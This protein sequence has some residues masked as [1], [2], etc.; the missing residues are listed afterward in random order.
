MESRSAIEKAL[1]CAAFSGA[2]C[3]D[4]IAARCTPLDFSRPDMRAVLIALQS[5]AEAGSAL[6]P[7]LVLEHLDGSHGIPQGIGVEL[8][9]ELASAP[10][11]A[12][13]IEHYCDVLLRH[14]A[15]DDAHQLGEQLSKEPMVDEKTI[16]EYITKLDQIQRGRKDEIKTAA[17]AVKGLQERKAN[18]QVIHKTGIVALDDKLRGGL[19]DGQIA[20]IGGRPGAG[21]SVLLTQI[22]ASIAE[23]GEGALIVSLEMMKEEIIDRL[24]RTRTCEKLSSMPLYFID[25]TSDLGVI[26]SLIRVACRRYRIGVIAIDY[27]QLA[28]VAAGRNENRERQIATISRRL[29]RLAMD[30]QKPVIVGSQ[31][32]RESTKRGKPSLADL[33]ESGSIEQDADIVILLSKSDDG[34]ETTIDIAKQ[35][36]GSL[37]E[38]VMRLDGPRFEFIPDGPEEYWQGRL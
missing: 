35:R 10:W 20:V 3:V 1:V 2:E 26:C 38:V 16:D 11:E 7:V 34:P 12:S 32:N 28:E 27:L 37:G 36:G 33:R 22:A 9:V 24:S 30:L 23:R 15:T 8:L 31:L 29:K 25:S 6:D 14:A 4:Q 13:H 5:L 17:D 21:K 18:P 19:R